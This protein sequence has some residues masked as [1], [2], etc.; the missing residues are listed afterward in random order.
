MSNSK[1]PK[2][3]LPLVKVE[4]SSSASTS[5]DRS[6]NPSPTRVPEH[7]QD[8]QTTLETNN[9]IFWVPAIQASTSDTVEDS[10]IPG[11]TTKVRSLATAMVLQGED[12]DSDNLENLPTTRRQL[13]RDFVL[14]IITISLE[15]LVLSL[16]DD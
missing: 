1:N 12:L 7:G 14:K 4:S 3:P 10:T 2:I 5:V 9:E 16:E 8:F 15:F 11:A 13:S 6:A